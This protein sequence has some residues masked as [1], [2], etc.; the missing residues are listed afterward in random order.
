[1]EH[2]EGQ[3]G[4]RVVNEREARSRPRWVRWVITVVAMVAAH[5]IAVGVSWVTHGRA[6][7]LMLIGWG[8]ALIVAFLADPTSDRRHVRQG[9]ETTVILRHGRLAVLGMMS[10]RELIE[11]IERERYGR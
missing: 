6:S 1:M 4:G 10:R 8:V 9:M 5:S 11:L 3:V 2:I 7:G